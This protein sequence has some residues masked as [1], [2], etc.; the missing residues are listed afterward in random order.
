[1]T[2]TNPDTILIGHSLGAAFALKL[3]ERHP[4]RAAFFVAPAFGE[5]NNEFTPLMHAMADQPF[6]WS[7]IRRNCTQTCI[8]HADNDP[9]LP[10]AKAEELAQHLHTTVTVIEGAG[11]FNAASGYTTFEALR[12]CV[13]EMMDKR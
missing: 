11:H 6:D 3:L 2:K 1:M 12:D 10:M 5:T 13:I 9:Y 8:F 7:A 4:V